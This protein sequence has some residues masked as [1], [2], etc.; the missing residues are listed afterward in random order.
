MEIKV[1]I[2]LKDNRGSVGVQS[3]ECDPVFVAF[4]GDLGAALQRVPGLVEEAQRQWEGTP[5]Y[6]KCENLPPPP[7][8]QPVAHRQLK[9]SIRP[10]REKAVV[11]QGR[12]F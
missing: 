1:V 6:P 5:R 9:E 11:G 7:Q 12:M 4:E 2:V 8:P 10:A 3:P